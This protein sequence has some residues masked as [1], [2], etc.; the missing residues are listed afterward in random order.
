MGPKVTRNLD[1]ASRED[2]PMQRL[3]FFLFLALASSVFIAPLHAT[4]VFWPGWLGP[5][6]DGAVEY[7]DVPDQWPKSVTEDWSI[8]VGSGSAA[9]V[10]GNGRV[11]MHSRLQGDE[12]VTC[13]ELETGTILWQERYAVPYRIPHYGER[14]GD[15]PLSN[16]TLTD[17]RLFTFSVTGI[18]SAWDTSTGALLWRQDYAERLRDSHPRWGHSTSP[19]ID[20]EQ[21]II[22]FG[23]E[24]RGTLAALDVATGDEI[25]TDGEDGSCH[26]SPIIVEIEGIRQIVEWNHEAV[27]GVESRTGKRLW[28]H[29]MPHTGSNQNSPTPVFYKGRLIIGGENRGIRS[30]EPT[31]DKGEWKVAENWHQRSVSLNMA[32]AVVSGDSLYGLS[33]FKRG[34]LFCLDIASGEVL[35]EGPSRAGEYATFLTLP[36]HIVHLDDSASLQVLKADESAYR[37]VASYEV[38][39]SPT[40]TAPVLLEDGFLVKDRTKLFKWSLD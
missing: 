31:L 35:W 14:H 15:G 19:L 40:W 28:S 10:V 20:G 12:V 29:R 39:E 13:V 26:A 27:V 21:V 22:H 30:L 3:S 4:D 8:V 38:G 11:Y 2:T 37:S 7:F 32:T 23:G 36:D 34:Q 9:P 25:W 33:H 1:R 24:R 18:L 17:S 6:R 16:P 5:D